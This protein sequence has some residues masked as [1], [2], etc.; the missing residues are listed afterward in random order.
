MVPFIVEQ[1]E[2]NLSY[3]KVGILTKSLTNVHC[4]ASVEVNGKIIKI[5]ISK[6]DIDWVPFKSQRYQVDDSDFSDDGR[7]DDEDESD[8]DC[9]GIS[10]TMLADNNDD[11]E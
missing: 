2:M 10:E 7:N 4:E 9:D 11:L 6:V 3:G 5:G 1:T 8:D